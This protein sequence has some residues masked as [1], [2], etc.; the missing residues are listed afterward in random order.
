MI[1]LRE[2]LESEPFQS[3]SSRL[4]V[5]LGKGVDGATNV[6]DL[7]RMPHLLIAGATGSGKSVLLNSMIC[8]VLYKSSPDEV[9]LILIDPKRLELGAYQDIPHLLTP[10]VTEP[11]QASDVLKWAVFEM[12]N[13]IKMLASE[14][15]RNIE[16]YNNI[17]RGAIEA[18]EK[19]QDQD[20]EPLRPMPYILLIIDELAD[21]MI[22]NP[23]R[24]VIGLRELLESEPFQASHPGSRWR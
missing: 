21:L 8:S 24:E 6:S 23:N 11:K 14:G 1:G 9:K 18:G 7:T 5:A 10:V 12:E 16:Q 15:V 20:G 2:L 3:S 17:L 22:P 19:R 13:R 4:T